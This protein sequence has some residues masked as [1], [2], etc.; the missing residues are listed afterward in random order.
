MGPRSDRVLEVLRE[1][2][3]QAERTPGLGPN[4]P[5]V[6]QLR[7]ILTRWTAERHASSR[8]MPSGSDGSLSGDES[9]RKS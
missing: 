1:T 5:G 2:I 3:E 6:L 9:Q 8:Q 4:D 7:Q